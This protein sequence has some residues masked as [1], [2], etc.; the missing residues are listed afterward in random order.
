MDAYTIWKLCLFP[1]LPSTGS[2][3]RSE[4]AEQREYTHVVSIFLSLPGDCMFS[5]QHHYRRSS[6]VMGLF[7]FEVNQ[8]FLEALKRG[9]VLQAPPQEQ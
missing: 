4:Q 2:A 1:G 6:L 9:T 3:Q 5:I 8:G 7:P